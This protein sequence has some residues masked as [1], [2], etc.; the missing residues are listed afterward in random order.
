MIISLIPGSTIG[1][2]IPNYRQNFHLAEKKVSGEKFTGKLYVI[3]YLIYIL[4]K[5]IM[6]DD[7]QENSHRV[8]RGLGQGLRP[9]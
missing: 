1:M 5:K 9:T 3:S 8:A 7:H 4:E 6:I 2:D